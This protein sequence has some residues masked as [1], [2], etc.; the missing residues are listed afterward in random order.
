MY[1]DEFG[2]R[3]RFWI[4]Q[5][6]EKT[7]EHLTYK[8][9]PSLG[10]HNDGASCY[11]VNFAFAGPDE[12]EG[13]EFFIIDSDE[14]THIMKPEKYS[15]VI[16]LGG[17]YQHGVSTISGGFREMFSTE[18]WAYPDMPSGSTLWNAD[19]DMMEDHIESCNKDG[20]TSCR[21]DFPTKN[22]TKEIGIIETQVLNKEKPAQQLTTKP[23]VDNLVPIYYDEEDNENEAEAFAIGLPQ[24]LSEE[25][26]TFIELEGIMK[27]AHEILYNNALSQGKTYAPE[28]GTQ[29]R[30]S[31]SKRDDTDITWLD[32]GDE[33]SYQNLISVLRRGKFS[34][35]LKSMTKEFNLEDLVIQG[36][37]FSFLS[38]FSDKINDNYHNDIN[39]EIPGTADTS[40]KIILPIHIPYNSSA[41]LRLQSE[42]QENYEPNVVDDYVMDDDEYFGGE[43]KV[44]EAL[45]NME[46]DVGTVI[47]TETQLAAMPC[48]YRKNRDFRISAGIY[49]AV[50]PKTTWKRTS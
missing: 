16:F 39:V 47:G 26:Q 24:Q 23:S 22:A 49:L 17:T 30:A 7:S 1:L 43:L 29:W 28:N 50:P 41:M 38:Y 10:S 8:D 44:R 11:T 6:K 40:F 45:I 12:Y 33:R 25:F 46:Y 34:Q 2:K 9:F 20:G 32:P 3:D 18:Y 42:Y 15:C 5:A 36:V 4:D 13:G 35:T 48:D 14:V 37:E 31:S 19:P 21:A 27:M